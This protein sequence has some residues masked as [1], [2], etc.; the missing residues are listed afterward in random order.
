MLHFWRKKKSPSEDLSS[1]TS[2]RTDSSSP[3]PV[4]TTPAVQVTMS[5]TKFGVDDRR[6]KLFSFPRKMQKGN[7][8]H[9]RFPSKTG[10]EDSTTGDCSS[11]SCSMDGGGGGHSDDGDSN[12]SSGTATAADEELFGFRHLRAYCVLDG[13]TLPQRKD[14]RHVVRTI[15]FK[16]D[17]VGEFSFSFHRVHLIECLL[18]GTENERPLTFVEPQNRGEKNK[19]ETVLPGEL[20]LRINGTSVENLTKD[21]IAR[22]LQCA[23]DEVSLDVC[24]APELMNYS[25]LYPE[26]QQS[27]VTPGD[28]DVD[29]GQISSYAAD[30]WHRDMQNSELVSSVLR[31][32]V[33]N[34]SCVWL[35]H[36]KGFCPATV[37]GPAELEGTL[38]IKLDDLDKEIVVDE[39]DIERRN[40]EHLNYCEDL[41]LLIFLNESSVGHVLRM[42][43]LRHLP[44]TRV[45][46][47][48]TICLTTGVAAAPLSAKITEFYHRL[49]SQSMPVH[50]FSIAKGVLEKI[51]ATRRSGAIVFTGRS[52]SGKTT[53]LSQL[54]SFMCS[55][56]RSKVPRLKLEAAQ[57]I[58]S[59]FGNCC[60]MLNASASRYAALYSIELDEKLDVSGIFVQ[61]FLLE[62]TRVTKRFFG[63]T[64]FFVFYFMWEGK[65]SDLRYILVRYAVVFQ[66]G[67]S[68]DLS[69][70]P[71]TVQ[72]L[73]E[74]KP[75]MLCGRKAAQ[76]DLIEEP[77]SALIGGFDQVLDCALAKERWEK[78]LESFRMLG[79]H[80]NAVSV[81]FNMLAAVFH[82]YYAGSTKGLPSAKSTFAKPVHAQFAADL[83]GVDINDL[84]SAIFASSQQRRIDSPVNEKKGHSSVTKKDKISRVSCLERLAVTQCPGDGDEALNSFICNLYRET[85][86][87]V[88]DLINCAISSGK[89]SSSSTCLQLIDYPGYQK[90]FPS[91]VSNRSGASWA[92]FAYNYV[93]ERIAGVYHDSCFASVLDAYKR[94]GLDVQFDYPASSP[95]GVIDVIDSPPKHMR[96]N[97]SPSNKEKRGILWLLDDMSAF[98][99]STDESFLERLFA[100][101]GQNDALKKAK[102]YGHFTIRH[103]LGTFPVTYNTSGWLKQIRESVFARTVLPLLQNSKKE[104]VASLFGH[105][106]QS[107]GVLTASSVSSQNNGGAAL[108]RSLSLMKVLNSQQPL[109]RNSCCSYLKV[110]TDVLVESIQRCSDCH[111]LHCF[112]PS[113]HTGSG[114]ARSAEKEVTVDEAVI[115]Q[116][117]RGLHLVDAVRLEKIGYPESISY[118]ELL[119]QYKCLQNVT[120]ENSSSETNNDRCVATQL[121]T[122]LGVD[123]GQVKFGYSRVFMKCG[124]SAFLRNKRNE[125]FS[126]FITRFQGLCRGFLARRKLA[127]L[128]AQ[129]AAIMI[130]QRNAKKYMCFRSWP[131]WKLYTRLLPVLNV[132]QAEEKIKQ[133]GEELETIR[134]NVKR[135]ESTV[136]ELTKERDSLQ[137]QILDVRAELNEERIDNTRL[138]QALEEET[139]MRLQVDQ[140]LSDLKERYTALE[141]HFK[142]QYADLVQLQ[143]ISMSMQPASSVLS[144]PFTQ[145]DVKEAEAELVDAQMLQRS[146]QE[147]LEKKETK[148]MQELAAKA[149]LESKLNDLVKENK[150]LQEKASIYKNR[151]DKACQEL[152]DMRA[153]VQQLDSANATLAQEKVNFNDKLATVMKDFM[154]AQNEKDALRHEKDELLTRCYTMERE[155]HLLKDDLLLS[156]TKLKQREREIS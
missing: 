59:S 156:E 129:Q 152:Q 106:H 18:D 71:I 154:K 105:L 109:K 128:R 136:S 27:L 121:L 146:L 20:L 83:L 10:S 126:E 8:S 141:T 113:M 96:S 36:I 134:E 150:S 122:H 21:E 93:N 1:S 23:C 50:L 65:D 28:H 70:F 79:V 84:Q 88:T 57:F 31:R 46:S 78:L 6:R 114:A 140:E 135:F 138:S 69:T 120:T 22:L 56:V 55:S 3:V 85:F 41:R 16:R 111:F 40:P 147:A 98:T 39:S 17:K 73:I 52:G 54:L 34:G 145:T 82:L 90:P 104:T 66:S 148:I 116:Q 53:Q 112:V 25:F 151:A 153:N 37:V 102:S 91:R 5:E 155:L 45:A 133:Q 13:S 95:F 29:I 63:E 99:G 142:D 67:R 118:A 76:L 24:Q 12:A 143:Q 9:H 43:F 14:G 11:I 49:P 26:L 42:R 139:T 119:Q 35:A 103:A 132:H 117:L 144:K 15:T 47:H 77:P 87:L 130:I 75:L 123:S 19:R 86:L 108:K 30:F 44:Y 51:V 38:R 61:T 48:S 58:L 4:A 110:Q 149:E 80:R 81:V 127:K 137:S 72:R 125:F 7:K 68:I 74:R 97:L 33:D 115:R 124:V 94:E 2:I 107:Y 89:P 131:W 100:H 32:S 62:H 92:E 101:Y 60:T 64:N